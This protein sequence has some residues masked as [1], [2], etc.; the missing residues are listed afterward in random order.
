MK[1]WVRKCLPW[2]PSFAVM[3]A[4]F[5]ASSLPG[6][7]VPLPDFFGSDKVAH[8]SA[9]ALLG[10]ALRW[11]FRLRACRNQGWEWPTLA[12]GWAF[13]LSDELHQVFIPG[14]MAGMDDWLADALGVLLGW[15]VATSADR[16]YERR[17]L[18]ENSSARD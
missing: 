18:S 14:R 2:L 9:Y 13:G 7:D 4:I 3:V 12:I 5:T 11:R 10:I 16:A 17:K 8:L 1:T 15:W 6:K